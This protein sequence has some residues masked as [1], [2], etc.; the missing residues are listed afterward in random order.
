MASKSKRHSD[1]DGM[2]IQV[3]K[4]KKLGQSPKDKAGRQNAKSDRTSTKEIAYL[5][6]IKELKETIPSWDNMFSSK[7]DPEDRSQAWMRLEILGE[8]LIQKYA[9]AIPDE[10]ALKICSEFG[11]IIE[12]GAGKGYWAWLL[13][14][15]GVDIIAFDKYAY[16]EKGWMEVKKGDPSVLSTDAAKSGRLTPGSKAAWTRAPP[17]PSQAGA[18]AAMKD[19]FNQAAA[20]LRTSAPVVDKPRTLLLSYPDQGESMASECLKHFQGDTIIHVGEL[21]TGGTGTK[22]GGSQAPWGK[23]T[24]SDFQVELAESFHCVLSYALPCMPFS[25]DYLTVWVRTK[26]T[27]GRSGEEGFMEDGEDGS[28]HEGEAEEEEEAAKHKGKKD[29]KGGNTQGADSKAPTSAVSKAPVAREEPSSDDGDSAMEDGESGDGDGDGDEDDDDCWA[30]IPDDERLPSAN[31]AAP[32]YAYLLSD[33][34]GD[35]GRTSAV[36]GTGASKS[37]SS[38]KK[39]K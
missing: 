30:D 15:R 38:N 4:K 29:G 24:N 3:G 14:Q 32:K 35:A 9:W 19:D 16:K 17:L 12:V 28:A 1:N 21:L 2:D 6:E 25:K 31:L 37:S 39:S 18:H 8:P 33:G 36:K 11:P 22:S 7:V 20:P 34:D 10:R 5:T 26:W 13:K 27:A 23:T